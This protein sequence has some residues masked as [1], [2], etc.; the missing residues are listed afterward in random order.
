VAGIS[1]TNVALFGQVN[2]AGV[3]LMNLQLGA[4][5]KLA[6]T[7]AGMVKSIGIV[8]TPVT[9]TPAGGN[10]TSDASLGTHFRVTLAGDLNL[11]TPSNPSDGQRIVW[12]FIQDGAGNHVLTLTAGAGGF[13]LGADISTVVLSTTASKID[14]MTTIYNATNDRHYVV[15][16][17]KGY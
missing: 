3:D 13:A 8:P 16:F 7:S 1:D 12:E 15:A 14:Y 17:V 6:V 9:L 10:I 5:L 11:N 4:A 2:T